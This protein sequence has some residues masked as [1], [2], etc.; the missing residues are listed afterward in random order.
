MNAE[1]KSV[2]QGL[3]KGSLDKSGFLLE[4]RTGN[5]FLGQTD[6][7][8]HGTGKCRVKSTVTQ[9]LVVYWNTFN[10]KHDLVSA[11][12]E[13]LIRNK[14]WTISPGR[15][16]GAKDEK[17]VEL[18][19]RFQSRVWSIRFWMQD[20]P[21]NPP[22]AAITRKLLTLVGQLSRGRVLSL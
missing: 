6:F 18:L 10:R 14:V 3:R 19:M 1:L 15:V 5:D 22:F 21:T 16:V 8:L 20:I 7:E 11:A 4:L 2:L 17:L 12:I 13:T 9:G